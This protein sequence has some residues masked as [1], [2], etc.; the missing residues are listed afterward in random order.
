MKKTVKRITSGIVA[1]ALAAVTAISASA[2]VT[3][4]LYDSSSLGGVS[5]SVKYTAGWDASTTI[6]RNVDGYTQISKAKTGNNKFISTYACLCTGGTKTSSRFA[7]TLYNKPTSGPTNQGLL[8]VGIGANY[9]H[10]GAT[11]VE[12]YN[13]STSTSYQIENTYAH[14]NT[15][16]ALTAYG[17]IEYRNNTDTIYEFLTNS[18]Y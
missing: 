8:V 2:A 17:T 11:A 3:Y 1:V 4:D 10:S 9:Y 16:S 18:N 14:I 6:N 15:T 13:Q 5:Y 7:N 12:S